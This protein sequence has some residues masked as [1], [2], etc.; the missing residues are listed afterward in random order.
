MICGKYAVR[1]DLPGGGRGIAITAED[2]PVKL[3]P[4]TSCS[5]GTICLGVVL[6]VIVKAW[7]FKSG[8]CASSSSCFCI[9]LDHL[10]HDH[11]AEI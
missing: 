5:A 7:G 2:I 4:K 10:W 8:S 1:C 11:W 3:R 9:L 6:S